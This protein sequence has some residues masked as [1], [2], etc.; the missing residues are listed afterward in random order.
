MTGVDDLDVGVDGPGAGRGGDDAGD[1]ALTEVQRL[2]HARLAGFH[3]V[4]PV[5]GMSGWALWMACAR[6]AAWARMVARSWYQVAEAVPSGLLGAAAMN[7]TLHYDTER[8]R[9]RSLARDAAVSRCRRP[10]EGSGDPC[11]LAAGHPGDH[12]DPTLGGRK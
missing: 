6:N 9:W 3:G 8:A 7:S 12:A 4:G 1:A 5:I 10:A 11:T 2:L